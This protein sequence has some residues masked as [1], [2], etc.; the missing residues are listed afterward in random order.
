MTTGRECESWCV[1]DV[2]TVIAYTTP[3]GVCI[4]DLGLDIEM[5]PAEASRLA[6]VLVL[7]AATAEHGRV[8]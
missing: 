4:R 6:E 8:S 7:A 2:G 3:A 5:T 1:D